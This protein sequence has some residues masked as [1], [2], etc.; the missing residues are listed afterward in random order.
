MGSK[1]VGATKLR[2]HTKMTQ[3]GAAWLTVTRSKKRPSLAWSVQLDLEQCSGCLQPVKLP[4][5]ATPDLW[6]QE[7]GGSILLGHKR[8]QGRASR[9]SP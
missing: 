2:V 5:S 4:S 9:Q 7:G 1:G 3:E 6:E 8:G